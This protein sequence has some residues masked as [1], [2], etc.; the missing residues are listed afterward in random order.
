MAA[1][2]L[3]NAIFIPEPSETQD[4]IPHTRTIS[5]TTL[6]TITTD[7]SHPTEPLLHSNNSGS[8]AYQ[9]LLS[10]QP[11]YRDSTVGLSFDGGRPTLSEKQ[12]YREKSVKKRLRILKFTGY[13]LELI[14]GIWA[15]YNTIRYFIAYTMFNST[16]GQA[17][18]L[19]LGTSTAVCATCLG[20]AAVLSAF[21]LY[22]IRSHV[23]IHSLLILRT[24]FRYL[25][26]FCLLSPAIVNLA[27]TIVWRNSSIPELVPELRC[28]LDVDIVWSVTNGICNSTVF[29]QWLGLAIFRVV[30]T[31]FLTI[32][33]LFVSSA[34]NG[35]RR[36]SHSSRRRSQRRQRRMRSDSSV[37]TSPP[38]TSTSSQQ[39]LNPSH[40]HPHP[41]RRPSHASQGTRRTTPPER[42]IRDS[43]TSSVFSSSSSSDIDDEGSPPV[44]MSMRLVNNVPASGTTLNAST[45]SMNAQSDRELNNFADHFRALVS[46][47]SREA[48]DALRLAQSQAFVEEEDPSSLQSRDIYTS[49]PRPRSHQQYPQQYYYDEYGYGYGYDN[50]STSTSTST[51]LTNS[52]N[53]NSPNFP[54]FNYPDPNQN[55]TNLP[56]PPQFPPQF[57]LPG[58]QDDH[59]HILNGFVRR[60][61]TIESLGSR[62]LAVSLAS[63]SSQDRSTSMSTMSCPPT[64]FKGT[65]SGPPSRANNLN[66]TAAMEG[67]A[68]S[69][70]E[71]G[72]V[73]EMGELVDVDVVVGGEGEQDRDRDTDGE[74]GS[75]SRS[76]FF[77]YYTAQRSNSYSPGARTSSSDPLT[78][79]SDTVIATTLT[80][81][82]AFIIHLI[83]AE[84]CS[85]PC[86]RAFFNP[87]RNRCFE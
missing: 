5:S 34:Y 32:L 26:S 3:H 59:I 46:Q 21:Q 20:C 22:L 81:G 77:S 30:L 43:G 51:S 47:I 12:R 52:P 78:P 24:A 61:L 86:E 17:A 9:D 53:P 11:G 25:A 62:E 75:A 55:P 13:I 60:M 27:L 73:E 83:E 68:T 48:D 49:L 38:P 74:M 57:P 18:A 64:E 72:E 56:F 71:V 79:S 41:S 2:Y 23:P 29:A 82:T 39:P 35:T 6:R 14:L 63:R 16:P 31:G 42:S 7:Q 58:A 50:T 28:R 10:M 70:T 44:Q 85:N 15:L 80:T 45:S 1:L 87:R 54:T 69:S 37:P 84:S 33:F 4:S 36:A 76:T 66:L 65:G 67:L 8:L 19:A 40:P